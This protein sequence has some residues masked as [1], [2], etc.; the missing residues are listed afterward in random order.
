MFGIGFLFDF[1]VTCP[2]LPKNKVHATHEL[3]DEW[4]AGADIQAVYCDR[5]WQAGLKSGAI[6][7]FDV[8]RWT[9]D[10]RRSS[11]KT[12]NREL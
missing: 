3:P 7:L 8:G 9:F 1:Q 2:P 12:T 6:S 4:Q 11:F 5:R 10:V